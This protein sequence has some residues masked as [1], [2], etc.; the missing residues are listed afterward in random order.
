MKFEIIISFIEHNEAGMILIESEVMQN[1]HTRL[2]IVG[3]FTD[4]FIIMN[5]NF[6]KTFVFVQI[7][8]KSMRSLSEA[9]SNML[10]SN[11]NVLRTCTNFIQ[12]I[13]H[14]QIAIFV[15]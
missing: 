7:T 13:Q 12:T 3:D 9:P 4:F 5:E 11:P 6:G 15:K 14:K 10:L 1:S 8:H 2:E